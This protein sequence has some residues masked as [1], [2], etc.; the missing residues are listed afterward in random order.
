MAE[1]LITVRVPDLPGKVVDVPPTGQDLMI[2]WTSADNVTRKYPLSIIADFVLNG[3]SAGAQP[4]IN[5]NHIIIIIDAGHVGATTYSY[6]ALAGQSFR[7]TRDGI[8]MTVGDDD[9][10]REYKILASGGWALTIPGDTF[11]LGQRFELDVY[12]LAGGGNTQIG[13]EAGPLFSGKYQVNTNLPMTVAD[14][15]GKLMQIRSGLTAPVTVTL[16]N[17]TDIPANAI[18]CFEADINNRAQSTIKSFGGQAILFNNTSNTRIYIG[19]GETLWLY[20][21]T[22]SFSVIQY[23]GNQKCVGEIISSFF[24][25][26]DPNALILDGS[27][28]SRA[29]WPRL[30]DKVS[31]VA[32]SDAL[33]Q[34][35]TQTVE[36]KTILG[37]Y[38][39]CF[40]AGDGSSTFRLPDFR[41]QMVRGLKLIGS[42][43]TRFYNQPGGRQGGAIEAHDHTPVGA[44]NPAGS[45][46]YGLVGKAGSTSNGKTVG[47]VDNNG[48]GADLNVID[49]P[50]AMASFG[51]SETRVDNV[52][53]IWMVKA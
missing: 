31:G 17:L 7:L 44:D 35:A 21:D 39:G 47:S 40:S 53:L 25:V 1:E 52:G 28:V 23:S 19:P 27:T 18:I 20:R 6:P 4:V 11:I 24:S 41:G 9:V 10:P 46:G 16:P 14:H 12:T 33:W 45:V 3:S 29:T 34:T 15:I 42:D 48:R 38:R 22:D 49:A 36:G 30:W 50:I 26:P 2:V 5:G 13:G 32:I 43:P 51:I 37:P 8:P